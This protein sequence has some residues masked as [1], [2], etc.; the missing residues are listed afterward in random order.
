[1]VKKV[2]VQNKATDARSPQIKWPAIAPPS[3]PFEVERISADLIVVDG[4]FSRQTLKLWRPFLAT[5]PMVA[6]APGPPKAGYAARMNNRLSVQDQAFAE[7]LWSNSGLKELCETEDTMTR[8]GQARPLGLNPNIRVYSYEPGHH[9]GAHYDDD[10]Y[11]PITR[12]RSEWTLLIYLTGEEDGVVGE[13]GAEKQ[14][15]LP[16]LC[17]AEKDDAFLHRQ[18]ARQHSTLMQT[19]KVT[20]RCRLCR[21]GQEGRC[22]I[23]TVTHVCSTRGSVAQYRFVSEKYR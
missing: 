23:G 7:A 15:L 4:F 20:D 19:A 17:V 13:C 22:Y 12:R 6:P 21:C 10:F 5:L 14:G 9:F 1:M 2:S 11:D 8:G 3:A 16:T 18:A